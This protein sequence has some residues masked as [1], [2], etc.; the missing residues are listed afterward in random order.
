MNTKNNNI[1]IIPLAAPIYSPGLL[2]LNTCP[3]LSVRIEGLS[4]PTVHNINI[5]VFGLSKAGF[6][7]ERTP[8][9]SG[10]VFLEKDCDCVSINLTSVPFRIK[11]EVLN[12]LKSPAPGKISVEVTIDG[13][14]YIGDSPITLFPANI[15]PAT[16]TPAIISTLLSPFCKDVS[17]ITAKAAAKT[18]GAL[19]D[20]VKSERIIYSVRECDFTARNVPFYDV[21]S[22]YAGRSKMASPLE[23]AL[24]FCSCALN[25]GLYPVIVTL[26]GKKAPSILCGTVSSLDE[27]PTVSTCAEKI[28]SLAANGNVELFNISC[29]FTGHSVELEDAIKNAGQE[30]FTSEMIFALNIAN[31]YADG[32]NLCHFDAENYEAEKNLTNQFRSDNSQPT[33]TKTLSQHAESLTDTTASPLLNITRTSSDFVCVNT[34][35]TSV[36]KAAQNGKVLTLSENSNS[37]GATR[38]MGEIYEAC[39]R[40]NAKSS[41]KN[42]LYLACGFFCYKGNVAPIALYPA[43][44]VCKNATVTAKFNSP[45]PY[46]N[47]LLC[48]TLKTFAP[49]KAFF[50]K[51]GIPGGD[52]DD[53]IACFETLCALVPGDFRIIKECGVGRF[54]YRNSTI[55]FAIADKC[56]K[57]NSDPLSIAILSGNP[58]GEA[59]KNLPYGKGAGDLELRSPEIFDGCVLDAAAHSSCGDVLVTDACGDTASDICLAVASENIRIGKTT[60][61][62]SDDPQKRMQIQKEFENC[63]LSNAVLILSSDTDIKENIETKLNALSESVLPKTEQNDKNELLELQRK[64]AAY[65]NSKSKNYDFEFSF[66]DAATAYINAGKGL[67]A[68][69]KAL[70]IEPESIFFPDLSKKSA[71]DIFEAQIRLC[72]AASALPPM[73]YKENPFF[74]AG[75]VDETDDAENLRLLADMALAELFE[76]VENCKDISKKSGFDLSHIKTLPA[77]HAFLSLIVLVSKE[78]DE[79]ISPSL[80]SKDIYPIS[81][82]I[83]ELR[84]I[85]SEIIS[86][87]KEL[88]EFDREVFSLDASQLLNEWNEGEIKHS[89]ISKTVN[90]YRISSPAEGFDKKSVFD[91][92]CLIAK[93]NEMTVEFDG[94]SIQMDEIFAGYW[95]GYNTDWDKISALVDFSKMADVLLK[96][97]YGHDSEKRHEAAKF[98]PSLA[99]Y[100]SDKTS[101]AKVI[102]TASLFDKMFSEGGSVVTLASKLSADLY[103]MTFNSGIF[104]NDGISAT[105]KGWKDSAEMLPLAAKYNKCAMECKKVGLS[106]FVNYLENNAYTPATEKIFTRSLLFLALKQITLYDRNFLSMN[107]FEEDSERYL[108][109]LKELCDYNKKELAR[110]YVDFCVSYIKANPARSKAFS[111][112]LSDKK[113]APEELILR[114]CETVKTLFP[115][116]IAEASYAGMI[117]DAENL[118][119]CDADSISTSSVLP[120]LYNGRHKTIISGN[121]NLIYMSENFALDCLKANVFEISAEKPGINGISKLSNINYLRSPVS[122]YD[123]ERNTNVLEAQTI[124]LEIMKNLSE[125]PENKIQVLTFTENQCET[126]YEVLSAVS[127]KSIAVRKA[128]ANRKISV[129]SA[130]DTSSCD[131]DMLYISPVF[132][133]DETS[134]MSISCPY[135]DNPKNEI[136]GL[137]VPCVRALSGS[138]DKTVAV[139][140]PS[141]SKYPNPVGAYGCA[142]IA[143]FAEYAYSKGFFINPYENSYDEYALEFARLMSENGF[144]VYTV[145]SGRFASVKIGGR[146]YAAII[147]SD[148]NSPMYEAKILSK[149]GFIPLFIDSTEL[150]L[151]P[152][153][154]L[155]R[156]NSIKNGGSEI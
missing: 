15:Y 84:N 107:H 145:N 140:A 91:T 20:A 100:S 151:N 153:K 102:G 125:H 54:P 136:F 57:I 36:T 83:A 29:L 59:D 4:S 128:L 87:E 65:S 114:N 61:I 67:T 105:V 154:I 56:D 23:M 126:V 71:S 47:R 139:F 109:L 156:I 85:A 58:L 155:D 134:G 121:K 99:K 70:H 97:I 75:L 81:K 98:F 24:I 22:F 111:E 144:S 131:C 88:C 89:D 27:F 118:I 116:I 25:M 48:E 9:F 7:I 149:K 2:A 37:G 55:S 30:L 143:L 94:S 17:R 90:A 110:S 8:A 150:L 69:E 124:G 96:K 132:D 44:L 72:R 79:G 137:P 101:V 51:I 122:S 21:G 66:D 11:G 78:Y 12:S 68:E 112:C 33:K 113:F 14:K 104:S 123:K 10:E 49:C 19:Y 45:K 95:N 35:L 142:K 92:L 74:R 141:F 3:V 40:I 146:Y 31:A 16:A 120:V 50:D 64:F 52:L 5:N 38:G 63:G 77:L 32:A 86:N 138:A 26:K 73:P 53:I 106:S 62:V 103:G 80:L 127:E 34:D 43:E 46:C 28:R 147:C 18:L 133:K 117:G 42:E 108:K 115:V 41:R 119:I 93:H 152:H 76:L 6:F 39:R 13:V 1:K 82:K 60:L 130:K 129:S 148:S 135:H